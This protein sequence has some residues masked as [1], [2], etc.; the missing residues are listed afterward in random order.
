MNKHKHDKEKK[1]HG[2]EHPHAE[3][4]PVNNVEITLEE[5]D[6]IKKKAAERDEYHDKWL[7]V[8]AEYENTRKRMEKEKS[9]HLRYA[10]E[11]I[12]TRILPLVDNFDLAITAID[13]AED[14]T[15]LLEGIKIILKEFHRV[16]DDNG[17]VKISA[18]GEQFDPNKHEAVLAVETDEYPEGT[19]I[20]EMRGGYTY[21]NRL[22]RPAQVKVA[23]PASEG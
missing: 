17:V 7:K 18:R 4:V 10:N 22:L 21:N 15:A 3:N 19:V 9:E 13:K 12:I 8:H 16:L 6:G 11:E 1:E 2:G 20:E 14:K 5:L 23:K